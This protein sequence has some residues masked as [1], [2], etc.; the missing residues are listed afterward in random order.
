MRY[1]LHLHPYLPVQDEGR[2][3]VRASKNETYQTERGMKRYLH[4]TRACSE[5]VVR[6]TIL[7]LSGFGTSVTITCPVRCNLTWVGCRSI[8]PESRVTT[9]IGIRSWKQADSE[10]RVY[11]NHGT[12]HSVH[13]C[14]SALQLVIN[15][16]KKALYHL[17]V[18]KVERCIEWYVGVKPNKK[19]KSR[20]FNGNGL[21]SVRLEGVYTCRS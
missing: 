9:I 15:V 20:D 21:S 19:T 1:Y 2:S 16:A 3:R 4:Y 6:R 18:L 12:C 13:E 8:Q 11:L 17:L 7:L 5:W 10:D 14:P